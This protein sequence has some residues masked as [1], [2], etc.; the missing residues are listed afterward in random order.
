MVSL[1]PSFVQDSGLKRFNMLQYQ[2][3][4]ERSSVESFSH[5]GDV[6]LDKLVSV[7]RGPGCRY[8]SRQANLYAA[9]R[10]LCTHS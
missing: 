6:E 2:A 5:V 3:C 7:R 4:N 1:G 10:H 8:I 9:L